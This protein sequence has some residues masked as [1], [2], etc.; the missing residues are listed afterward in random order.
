MRRPEV[1]SIFD[2]L[3][4]GV[5]LAIIAEIGPRPYIVR[6]IFLPAVRDF[7]ATGG[8]RDDRL[9]VVAVIVIAIGGAII[10]VA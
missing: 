8:N 9:I 4:A 10:A 5:P 7:V 6:A 3:R 2:A 1:R